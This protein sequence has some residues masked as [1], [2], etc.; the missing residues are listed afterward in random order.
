MYLYESE[1]L[2]HK[3]CCKNNVLEQDI[4]WGGGKD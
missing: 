3:E 4:W 2:S 1:W